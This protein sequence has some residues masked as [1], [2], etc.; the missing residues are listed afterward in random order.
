MGTNKSHNQAIR[1]EQIL[2]KLFNCDRCDI[3]GMVNSDFIE[4]NWFSCISLGLGKLADTKSEEIENFLESYGDYL[5]LSLIDLIQLSSNSN[6]LCE[7]HADGEEA[8][9]A[10][11][12][13]FADL[14]K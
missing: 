3:G 12:S 10:V 11:I 5:K 8:A 7:N 9:K 14:C 6:G 2:C 1:I 4:N 13:S